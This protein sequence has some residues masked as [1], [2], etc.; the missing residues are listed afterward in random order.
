MKVKKRSRRKIREVQRMI[1]ELPTTPDVLTYVR[2][3][4]SLQE[5]YFQG[6]YELVC[7]ICDALLSR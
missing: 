7:D 2:I 3:H 1:Q 5:L 4:Q 6:K